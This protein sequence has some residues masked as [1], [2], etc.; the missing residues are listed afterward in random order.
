MVKADSHME[1]QHIQRSRSRTHTVCFEINEQ[2]S[3]CTR[4]SDRSVVIDFLLFFTFQKEQ[5]TLGRGRTG[6]RNIGNTVSKDHR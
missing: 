5:L 3:V 1:Y 4:R 2:C 6:L